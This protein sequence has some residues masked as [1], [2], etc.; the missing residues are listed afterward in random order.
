MERRE[1]A[2]SLIRSA[3]A[4]P[5]VLVVASGDA[6]SLC[7]KNGLSLTE[8]LRPFGR[9]PQK[10]TVE[11]EK[12]SRTIKGMCCEFVEET[13]YNEET[14]T[15]HLNQV[16]GEAKQVEDPYGNVPL[17]NR[18]DVARLLS[19]KK[20]LTPWFTQFSIQFGLHIG[21]VEHENFGQ[22]VACVVAISSNVSDAVGKMKETFETIR[23]NIK[24]SNF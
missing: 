2:V 21:S 14:T 17:Y 8:L 1:S 5:K 3:L 10:A 12:S 7:Q 22:P 19:N 6:N 9:I 23:A 16:V 15:A 13:R 4:T 18:E 11:L 24:V 20:D